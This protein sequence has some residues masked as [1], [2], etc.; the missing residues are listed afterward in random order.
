MYGV[1]CGESLDDNIKRRTRIYQKDGVIYYTHTK[2]P[3]CNHMHMELVNPVILYDKKR[4]DKLPDDFYVV[5]CTYSPGDI[6]WEQNLKYAH[7]NK[8]K[9]VIV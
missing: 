9:R 7:T 3:T 6:E 2:C 1:I 4:K 8:F 5:E